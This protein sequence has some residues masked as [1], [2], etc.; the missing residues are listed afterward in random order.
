[1]YHRQRKLPLV[2]KKSNEF[3]RTQLSV[4]N[5]ALANR[6]FVTLIRHVDENSFPKVSFPAGELID[7]ETKGGDKYKN[8]KTAASVLMKARLDSVIVDAKG[9]EIGF[10]MENLFLTCRYKNGVV[11][12]EFNPGL[13]PHMLGLK[14]YFTPLNY[15]ELIELSSFYSQRI[16]EL[17]KSWENP[18]GFV[19]PTIDELYDF[20]SYPKDQRG[21]FS[22]VRRKVLEQAEKEINE[23]TELRFRWEAIKEGRKVVAVHFVIGEQGERTEKKRQTRKAEKEMRERHEAADQRKP[24]LLA[25]LKCRQEHGIKA[26]DICKLAKPRSKKCLI[27]TKASGVK[28]SAEPTLF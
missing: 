16:Y 21:N 2:I 5:N 20:I 27:C 6:I 28:T 4:E 26:G 23:K 14:K 1:M 8:L 7:K 15:F 18:E 9:K 17:L 12:A 22:S 25:A 10:H 24:H 19:T 13:K 3:A 11:T